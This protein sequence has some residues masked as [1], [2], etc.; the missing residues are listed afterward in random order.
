MGVSFIRILIAH[1]IFIYT[2]FKKFHWN[3][4][5]TEWS[6]VRYA[7]Q[8]RADRYTTRRATGSAVSRL[9]R[10]GSQVGLGE[11]ESAC[12]LLFFIFGW[13]DFDLLLYLTTC[14]C[15]RPGDRCN[16]PRFCEFL[17]IL[18]FFSKKC[19]LVYLKLT[20]SQINRLF[21][22]ENQK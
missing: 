14:R 22:W 21:W 2:I 3:A 8:P 9:D 11:Y 13:L 17:Q 16:F 5:S 6:S 10:R 12:T 20:F 4:R 15:P 1:T 18:R 19:K 7:R